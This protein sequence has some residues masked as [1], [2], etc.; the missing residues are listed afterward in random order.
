ML[1][2]SHELRDA[3]IRVEYALNQSAVGKQLNLANAR[4][5]RMAVVIGPDDRARGEVQLKDLAA[6]TQES[7]ARKDIAAVLGTR[8][9]SH[10]SPLTIQANG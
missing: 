3:G 4:H 6:K 10:V 8:L 1:R 2:L 5:A 7:V 9:T